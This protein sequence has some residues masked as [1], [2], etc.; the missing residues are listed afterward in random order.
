MN[1]PVINRAATTAGLETSVMNPSESISMLASCRDLA[2]DLLCKSLSTMLDRIEESLFDLAEKAGDRDSANLYLQARGEAQAKR[3][4]IEAEFRRQ[5]VDG[6]NR[7]LR[8][9]VGQGD[10]FRRL[11]FDNL[12]L[13]LVEQEAIEEDLAASNI[14]STLKNSCNEEL[15]ALNRRIG[16]LMQLPEDRNES[17]PMS[18]QAIVE[19]FRAAC[20]EIESDMN[21]RLLVLKQFE[22]VAAEN[23]SNVYQNLNHFL[24]ERN[25]LPVLPRSGYRRARPTA[26]PATPGAYGASAGVTPQM[27]PTLGAEAVA[28]PAWPAGAPAMPASGPAVPGPLNWAVGNEREI[29]A[30]L[31]QLLAFNQAMQA[32]PVAQPEQGSAPTPTAPVPQFV[33]SLGQSFLDALNAFQQGVVDGVVSDHGQL[34]ASALKSGTANV[35]HQIKTTSLA[36]TLGHVD[37]M[38]IDIV[39]MLFDYIFDDK[40]IPGPMK[41]L[42]GRLQIPVLKVAMLDSKFFARKQHP[43]RR[44]LDTLSVAALGWEEADGLDDRLYRKIA[45]IVE[46]IVAD[47]DEN[48]GIFDE[49]LAELDVFLTEE[50]QRAVAAAEEAA[51]QMV[52]AEREETAARLAEEAVAPRVALPDLPPVIRDFFASTWRQVLGRKVLERPDDQEGWQAAIQLMDDLVWSV[53]PKIGVE[54]RLKLVNLLPKLLKQLERGMEEAGVAREVRE[55]F[56]AELVHLHADAIKSGLRQGETKSEH[57]QTETGGVPVASAMPIATEPPVLPVPELPPDLPADPLRLDDLPELSF[58]HGLSVFETEGADWSGGFDKYRDYEDVV[59]D[60]LKR[61]AWVEFALAG[62][63]P[64]RARLTWVSP[65][66]TRFLFTNRQGQNGLEYS[67]E[68]LLGL[69]RRQQARLLERAPSVERA[70]SDM[71]G[72]LQG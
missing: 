35:L 70:V 26:A 10:S 38:T 6:F 53:A 16:M 51:R 2:A 37:A 30:T 11:D 39:A 34:D 54:A 32:M 24:I 65:R 48:I 72:M 59:A 61:G 22:R 8:N 42:I 66:R 49:A 57:A 1:A 44:L 21:V 36:A 18:P 13:S 50:E 43:T 7:M 15:L 12:E 64:V 29:I 63:E 3:A 52:A 5:F 33:S 55:R 23:V 46:R 28:M 25:I 60:E 45:D 19:A 47:F 67:L 17:N 4:A 71:I 14:A 58:E 62:T 27:P 68:E 40:N 69:F 56:F 41:A 9:P 31:Q 20:K